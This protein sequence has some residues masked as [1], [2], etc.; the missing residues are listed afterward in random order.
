MRAVIVRPGRAASDELADV[1]AP[2][3]D[4]HAVVD[5]IAVGVDGTDN[6]IVEGRYG[7]GPPGE[8]F[9][10]IGHESVGRVTRAAGEFQEG[11]L[12]TAIVRRPD[13]VPCL[14]CANGEWDMCLN[15]LYTERGIKSRHGFLAERY[16][17]DPEYLV[18]VP[19]ELE[20][21]GAL[22]EPTSIVEKAVE[23]IW[24]IQER[25]AW[26][27]K[28]ALVT[29][30]GPVGLLA[31]MLLRLRGLEVYVYDRV[32]DGPKPELATMLG[33]RYLAA[34]E[35]D[36]ARAAGGDLGDID[37]GIEATGYSPLSF[38]LV[39]TVSPNGI[40]ALTGVS[41]GTR[42]A[43]IA[44]DHLN[45][46]IVL[47]NKVVFGSVNA[48]RRHFEL[49]VD[50]LARAQR[51]WPGFFEAMVTRREPLINY[52]SALERKADDVKVIVEVGS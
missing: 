50:D 23:Q 6:E 12:V 32:S 34:A 35:A 1:P 28:T 8:D 15:G 19:V 3:M 45:M 33:A 26:E 39:D 24:R 20:P 10:I 40:V 27:P 36:L 31:T 7:S 16:A 22:V 51:R 2:V 41:S 9:L 11:D 48:N 37:I 49:A 13:P 46:E 29:G 5:V 52:R 17:E 18:R 44:T 30:S 14:N 43:Q 25:L 42:S 38:T 47:Q 21:V 4:D